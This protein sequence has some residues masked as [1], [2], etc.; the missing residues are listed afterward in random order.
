MRTLGIQACA[1]LFIV[2]GIVA[3]SLGQSNSPQSGYV[4]DEATAIRVAEAVFIPIYGKKHVISERP[5]Q[6]R[7]KGGSWIVKGSLPKAPKAEDIVVGG[8]M[9]AEIDRITGC[10]KAVYHLK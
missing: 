10:I 3:P 1:W 2:F 5:F 4:P 7:L 9:I 8:T 6:A